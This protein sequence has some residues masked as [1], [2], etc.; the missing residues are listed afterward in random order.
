MA[1]EVERHWGGRKGVTLGNWALRGVGGY[2]GPGFRRRDT[3]R[4]RSRASTELGGLLP[5]IPT[6]RS[7]P[8]SAARTAGNYTCGAPPQKIKETRSHWLLDNPRTQPSLLLT[9]GAPSPHVFAYRA[10]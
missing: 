6:P 10:F 2:D 1:L 7:C 9:W 4:P 3:R 8:G 5:A